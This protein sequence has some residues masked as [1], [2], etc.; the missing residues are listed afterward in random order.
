MP[1]NACGLQSEGFRPNAT[2]W[3]LTFHS[4]SFMR[5]RNACPRATAVFAALLI[6]AQRMARTWSPVGAVVTTRALPA[7]WVSIH[8]AAT[9]LAN[10]LLPGPW[11]ALIAVN[12]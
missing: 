9:R 3:L 7:G 1:W 12:R 11:H 10:L 5:P 4:V 6:S 8:H 2:S